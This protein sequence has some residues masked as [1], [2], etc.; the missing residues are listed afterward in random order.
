MTLQHGTCPAC[1]HSFLDVKPVSE[2]DDESS[3]GGEYNPEDRDDDVDDDFMDDYDGFS[4]DM[5]C[6]CGRFM[7]AGLQASN[8]TER[9]YIG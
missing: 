3:D 2:S 1:R 5:D 4:S 8:W 6:L 7:I 9:A